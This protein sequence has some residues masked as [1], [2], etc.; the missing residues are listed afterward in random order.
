M[1]TYFIAFIC[2]CG[3]A[4]GQVLFKLSAN[5]FN[6]AGTVFAFKPL[7]TLFSATLLYGVMTLA[8]I[9]VL[10]RIE[11]GKVYPI[12]ALAF[13]IVPV[14]SYFFFGEKFAFTYYLGVFFIVVGVALA[15]FS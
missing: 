7:C 2:V 9:W 6:S 14:M 11:L 8:W 3:L 13:V 15:S 5:L 4:L 1:S 12:M 10:Q